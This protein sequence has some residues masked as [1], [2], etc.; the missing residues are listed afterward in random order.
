[1][2]IIAFLTRVSIVF[3]IAGF[4]GIIHSTYKLLNILQAFSIEFEKF[5]C[6]LGNVNTTIVLLENIVIIH[7]IINRGQSK[8]R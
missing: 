7:D 8:S 3:R 1:M 4:W 6:R 5:Y 2:S